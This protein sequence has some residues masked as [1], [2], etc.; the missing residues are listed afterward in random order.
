MSSGQLSY[1]GILGALALLPLSACSSSDSGGSPASGGSPTSTGGSTSTAGSTSSGNSTSVGGITGTGGSSSNGGSTNFG[2]STGNGGSTN[3]GGTAPG[4]STSSGGSGGKAGSASSGGSTSVGGSTSQGPSVIGTCDPSNITDKTCLPPVPVIPS[5][6]T[7][8]AAPRT[9]AAA[10]NSGAAGSKNSAVPETITETLDNALITAGFASKTCVELSTGSGGANAFLIGQL[11]LTAG[12]TLVIDQ[13]VT[14]YASRN[15]K[16]YGTTCVVIDPTGAVTDTSVTADAQ[17][18]CGG[19]IMATGDHVAIMGKG[20]ID[21]Q[22]GE[23]L[24][25]VSPPT[26][27]IDT[28]ANPTVPAD[29]F[30]WWNV[31]DFQRHDNR[32]TGSGPGSA[33]NP[34]LIQV[35]NAS[36]FVLYGL[37]LYNSPFF[38]VQLNSDKFVVWGINLLTPS[39]AMSTGGQPLSNY[40]AR[41]T[42][43]IDPGAA[44]GITQNGYIVGNRVSTGDD[45]VALK[46]D[47]EGGAINIV[48][49]H[50]HFGTGHGMSMGSDTIKGISNV[51]VYDLTIDGDVP[52]DTNTGS[53]DLNGLRIKS[54]TG[55]G[56]F[57]KHVLFEDICTRDEAYPIFITASYDANPMVNPL[58]VP[59]DFQDISVNNFHQ[60]NVNGPQHAFQ[61]TV[62]VEGDSAH[63]ATVA[64]NN[65][66]V[67]TST[68]KKGGPVLTVASTATL[69]GTMNIG[70]PPSNDPCTGKTWWPALPTVP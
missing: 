47:A 24:L 1:F 26:K 66:Y 9:I 10:P 62:S 51:H 14:V 15:P 53:S 40:I 58:G 64:F 30:S 54:Y 35:S 68:G 44:T 61:T 25:G 41:N 22:G 5:A 11:K 32:A 31:S 52:V 19:V 50:N 57:V 16:S 18:D 42:D 13:G 12:Q 55:N 37:N 59:P 34:A 49:A 45:M 17:Y 23:P 28:V 70:T 33:P 27:D 7:K 69:T 4:G 20:T 6:C 2:G 56:G 67:D 60:L 36:N 38:H 65:V 21:G 3:N 39:N 48:V 29:S 63:Q 46:G 43:G 8:V